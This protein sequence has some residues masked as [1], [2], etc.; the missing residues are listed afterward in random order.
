VP[1]SVAR[2]STGGPVER[3]DLGEAPLE[4][5]DLDAGDQRRRERD[6]VWKTQRP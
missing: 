5:E 1:L 6:R 4:R 2:Q 3:G